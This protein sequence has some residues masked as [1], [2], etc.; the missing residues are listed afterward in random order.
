MENYGD[1]K[2]GLHDSDSPMNRETFKDEFTPKWNDLSEAYESGH[3]HVFHEKRNEIIDDLWVVF[4]VLKATDH[5]MRNRV[6]SII[7]KMM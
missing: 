6:L 4:E 3:E 2:T 7:E 5:G 1:Y